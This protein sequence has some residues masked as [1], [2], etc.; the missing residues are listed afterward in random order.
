MKPMTSIGTSLAA[1]SEATASRASPAPMRST[2]R[3][4]NDGISEESFLGVVAQVAA[5]PSRDQHLPAGEPLGRLRHDQAEV[6]GAVADL[7]AKLLFG[8]AKEVGAGVLRRAVEAL[9]GS[10]GLR[11]HRQEAVAA[12]RADR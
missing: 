6:L 8:K 11:V 12:C 10:V 2:I 5:P 9:V 3:V 7:Q 4:V 1:Q